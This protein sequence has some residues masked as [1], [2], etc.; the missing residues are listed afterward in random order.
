MVYPKFTIRQVKSL[1]KAGLVVA[2]TFI[3][4]KKIV[5]PGQTEKE[6]ASTINKIMRSSGAQGLA[7]RTIVAS[8]NHTAFPHHRPT[9]RKIKKND[10][11]LLDF[12]AKVNGFCS[13]MTR[14]IF[15]GQPKPEW[16]K[17]YRIVQSAH[18]K[19]IKYLKSY[20][21]NHKSCLKA[22]VLDS[23]ARDF[24][25]KRGYG[26]YFIHSL[27][28]GIG[29][30]PHQYF[31]IGPKSKSTIKPGFV[32]TI[33]PGIYLKGRFGVRFEDTVYLSKNGLV[34]FTQI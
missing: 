5:Q 13:D 25:T 29:T 18:Q 12:G 17:V 16:Q 2:E 26:R 34:I 21:L 14:V 27:G 30:R 20:I 22:N 10:L 28:H 6:I 23:L 7:F 32:F 24:I 1:Q 31:K 8:G 19:A 3:R 9:N 15:I 33:E 4:I 11:V